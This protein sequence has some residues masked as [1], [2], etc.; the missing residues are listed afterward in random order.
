[1]R[2]PMKLSFLFALV[3]AG[4]SDEL[5]DPAPAATGTQTAPPPDGTGGA[6]GA[7]SPPPKVRD[8]YLR[9]PLGTRTD[10]LI[11]DGDFEL[12][13][14]PD[15][16]LGGQYT[17]LAFNAQSAPVTFASETG[18]LCRNSLRCA[19]VKKG[20]ALFGRG[21]S[22]PQGAQ[23]EASIHMKLVEGSQAPTEPCA[24]ADVYMVEC[25]SGAIKKKLAPAGAPDEQ[26]WCAISSKVSGS[27]QSLCMYAEI[28]AGD[29]LVDDALLVPA[30]APDPL[31]PA[32]TPVT[33]P[34]EVRAR[35][36]GVRDY[37]RKHTT[38]GP[39]EAPKPRFSE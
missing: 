30:E 33:V 22:A 23:H 19:R 3:L 36:L 38:F 31:P 37:V 28:G 15:G 24:L 13:V 39:G 7:T 5:I 16:Y 27:K 6:G 8:V 26:G 21:T 35:I 11:A 18:G 10:N 20:L 2:R 9:N 1:M 14:I 32:P 25:D 4:C 34:E 17:W 12:S 29:V